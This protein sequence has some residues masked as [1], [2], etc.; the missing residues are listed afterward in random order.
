[1]NAAPSISLGAQPVRILIVDDELD[2]R[3]LLQIILGWEGFLTET[4]A[5]GEEA[6]V[7]AARQPPDLMLLDLMMPGF[8]GCEVLIELKRN[9]ALRHVPVVILSALTD[10][11]TQVRVLDAGAAAFLVK[12]IER[13]DLTRQVRSVLC[14]TAAAD[15]GSVLRVQ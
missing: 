9:P 15:A 7:S 8:D 4:A 6:L 1:M 14:L 5:S 10:R 11:A 13:A 2:N 12:P 3:E